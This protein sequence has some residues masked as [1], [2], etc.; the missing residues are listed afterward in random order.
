M[1]EPSP[2]PL[3]FPARASTRLAVGLASPPVSE[4]LCIVSAPG[5]ASL[6]A[7]NDRT[8]KSGPASTPRMRRFTDLW[9]AEAQRIGGL[10]GSGA[11]S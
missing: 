2:T 5:E 11:G 4:R 6:Q 9:I 8:A 1:P 10:S 3:Q 7:A